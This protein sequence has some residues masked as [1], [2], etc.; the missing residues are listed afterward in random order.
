MVLFLSTGLIGKLTEE[1]LAGGYT[2][3]TPAAIVYKATWPEE[4]VFRCTVGTLKQTA[5][6]NQITRTALIVVGNVLDCEYRRSDLYH[7]EF[8]T[9]YRSAHAKKEVS[10]HKRIYV[11]GMGPGNRNSMTY[12]AAEV[13]E[14]CQVIAGYTV[15]ADLLKKE[16]PGKEYL[17][18]PDASGDTEMSACI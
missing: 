18:T 6:K 1:L 10:G 13:I 2:E 16:Y 4:K 14:R 17:T 9:G 12:E 5:D 7:P 15:Y 3:D 11:I 8:S